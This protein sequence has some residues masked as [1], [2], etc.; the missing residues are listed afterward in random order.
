MSARYAHTRAIET[1][2]AAHPESRE[3]AKVDAVENTGN[4]N[5]G[6]QLLVI[7]PRAVIRGM[8]MVRKQAGEIGVGK[9]TASSQ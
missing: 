8:L 2:A 3:A 4:S 9:L 7:S 5:R 6:S 1:P